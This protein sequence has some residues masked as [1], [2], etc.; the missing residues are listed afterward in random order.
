MS[1]FLWHRNFHTSTPPY[2]HTSTPPYLHTS[3]PPHSLVPPPL[4]YHYPVGYSSHRWMWNWGGRVEPGLEALCEWMDQEMHRVADVKGAIL[5]ATLGPV[6]GL[7]GGSIGVLVGGLGL[8]PWWICAPVGIALTV[9]VGMVTWYVKT[10]NAEEK[11]HAKLR[12]EARGIIQRLWSARWMGRL[13][14]TLGDAP[15]FALNEAAKQALRCRNALDSPVWKASGADSPWR[16]TRD[17]A[18]RAMD[19]AMAQMVL[20]ATSG[21]ISGSVEVWKGG[22]MEVGDSGATP[23]HVHTSIPQHSQTSTPPPVPTST[24]PNLHT[25]TLSSSE[26]LLGEMRG[27]ADEAV[28]LTERMASRTGRSSG[29][30]AH[31]LRTALG[32]LKSLSA[33]EDEFEKARE[34]LGYRE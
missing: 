33:A 30:A 17:T 18:L 19:G 2:L 32:D 20:L 11:A 31:D 26:T 22:S 3:T 28:R 24:P 14:Q 23:P 6:W 21:A 5:G 4:K 13:K 16:K 27:M 15:A 1:V 12:G 8:S 7:A 25:S 10:R 29:N 34:E 9:T